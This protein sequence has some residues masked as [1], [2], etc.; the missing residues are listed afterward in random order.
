MAVSTGVSPVTHTA[1][2]ATKMALG[3]LA[4][5]GAVV[6]MSSRSSRV[7]RAMA[8]AKTTSA[9][10][11]GDSERDRCQRRFVHS[12]VAAA[13]SVMVSENVRCT[14]GS[15]GGGTYLLSELTG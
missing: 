8:A 3:Q 6:A 7:N 1:E 13:V 9:M 12:Q 15:G 2:V 5:P 14:L 11:A 4:G 10:R